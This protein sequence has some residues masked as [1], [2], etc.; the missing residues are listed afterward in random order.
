MAKSIGLFLWEDS[1]PLS[2]LRSTSRFPELMSALGSVLCGVWDVR[3]ELR[4]RLLSACP[5]ASVPSTVSHEAS[6]H[7]ESRKGIT[8]QSSWVV[9]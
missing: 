3:V 2:S 4:A 9:S 1:P 6:A 8:R 7:G 5:G